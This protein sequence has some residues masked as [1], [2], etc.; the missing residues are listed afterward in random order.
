MTSR[1]SSNHG[2]YESLHHH[3]CV[4]VDRCYGLDEINLIARKLKGKTVSLFSGSILVGTDKYDSHIRILGSFESDPHIQVIGCWAHARRKWSDALDEDKRTASEAL[5]YINK[6]Y[7]V[8]N[9]AKEA[10]ISGEALKE[11]RQKESYPVILQFEKWMYETVTKTSR[12]S[13]I[14]KA[15][16]YT[17]PLLPRLSRYVN[18]GRFCIDNN[19]VENAIRPLALGRKNYLFCGNHDAAVR[20]A[21]VYSLVDSCKALDVNP[22]EWMEDV[23]L[24]IPGNENNREALREQNLLTGPYLLLV[25]LYISLCNDFFS[26]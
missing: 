12:N 7:H 8:E 9:E 1:I 24:R 13:R 10:G 18:D 14:G 26:L 16:S 4:L 6:L 17:L 15:I 2:L 22:R 23:L 5:A 19:L 20:A 21:I 11:K 3:D 25:S